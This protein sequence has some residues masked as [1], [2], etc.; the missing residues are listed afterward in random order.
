[1]KQ[2]QKEKSLLK[3]AEELFIL[4]HPSRELLQFHLKE[5]WIM[6]LCH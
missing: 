5:S 3:T 6:V 1:M 4:E 2:Q